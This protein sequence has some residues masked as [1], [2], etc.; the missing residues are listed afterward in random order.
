VIRLRRAVGTA[1]YGA[2]A[3]FF[4]FLFYTSLTCVSKH[5][6]FAVRQKTS[7]LRSNASR[8]FAALHSGAARR[9]RFRAVALYGACAERRFDF[10]AVKKYL[11]I[12][13]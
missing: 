7:Q 1:L 9:P 12:F 8:S 11:Q 4:I 6:T 10:A 3:R 13:S 5:F 2:V